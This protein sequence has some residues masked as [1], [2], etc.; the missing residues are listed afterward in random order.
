[1]SAPNILTWKSEEGSL[2]YY[3]TGAEWEG[4]NRPDPF[5]SRPRRRWDD[6]IKIGL[7]KKSGIRI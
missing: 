5:V 7:K 1:V 3:K 2:P 4:N 6:N